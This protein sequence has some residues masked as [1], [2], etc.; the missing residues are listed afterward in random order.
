MRDIMEMGMV[1]LLFFNFFL[2]MINVRG[3][4]KVL[5]LLKKH[6]SEETLR[7]T[8][9]GQAFSCL[10]EGQRRSVQNQE[11][12]IGQNRQSREG[13]DR[14]L[15]Q[16]AVIPENQNMQTEEKEALLNEVLSEVFS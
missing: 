5:K 10:S 4:R 11:V 16:D 6:M 2:L 7:Q 14:A 13:L 15:R 8:G 1:A 3:N 12:V 9:M